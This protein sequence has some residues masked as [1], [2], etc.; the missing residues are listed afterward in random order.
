MIYYFYV[1]PITSTLVM[2]TPVSTVTT[3]F[4][5]F[6]TTTEISQI[7]D[8]KALKCIKFILS[9]YYNNPLIQPDQIVLP[10]D[11]SLELWLTGALNNG[12]HVG[13]GSHPVD[14]TCTTSTGDISIDIKSVSATSRS[15]KFTKS[16]SGETSL[17]QDFKDSETT[18]DELFTAG[19]YDEIIAKWISGLTKKLTTITGDIYYVFIVEDSN[20]HNKQKHIGIAIAKI[21]IPSIQRF[22]KG[23]VTRQA[24]SIPV[25]NACDGNYCYLK[26][27]KSKKRLELR[28]NPGELV[29]SG[30]ML[31]FKIDLV[32]FKQF[33]LRD[34][35]DDE[36]E[37]EKLKLI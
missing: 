32:E 23:I 9:R 11:S 12:K 15:G 16:Q 3:S 18:L 19:R 6:L 34:I 13:N 8:D 33:I 24:K 17:G 30:K 37:L 1:N 28:L 35:I 25:L 7:I 21:D 26:I 5:T 10:K 2:T 4:L 20:I 14:V 36:P 29:S 27:Y 31:E 22:T